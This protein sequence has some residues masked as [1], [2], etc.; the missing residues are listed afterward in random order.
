MAGEEEESEVWTWGRGAAEASPAAGATRPASP[1]AVDG[2]GLPRAAKRIA[3]A[4]RRGKGRAGGARGSR[5]RS[6]PGQP[7]PSLHPPRPHPRR[8]QPQPKAQAWALGGKKGSLGPYVEGRGG[9]GYD[10][11]ITLK[12]QG[13][14]REAFRMTRSFSF[15]PGRLITNW[16][17]PQGSICGNIYV[18]VAATDRYPSTELQLLVYIYL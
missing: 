15:L 17:S 13:R 3:Q 7:P 9:G 14:P 10:L 4:G 5:R 2:R 12:R 11:D 6:G 16:D 1:P 18:L 8:L